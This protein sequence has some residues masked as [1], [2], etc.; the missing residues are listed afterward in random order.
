MAQATLGIIGGSGLYAVERLE[1]AR[2]VRVETPFGL[3]SDD[4]AIGRI[5]GIDVA[6][7]PRHGKGHRLSPTEVPVRA[8]IWALKSL[9]VERIVS[10]SAVGSLRQELEP[11]H[12]VVPD[13]LIDRTR[14]RTHTFFEGGLVVHIAFA[15]PF[16][17]VL[18]PL[19][20][21]AA[22][23]AGGTVHEGG[24]LVTM[25][26]PQFSTKAESRMYRQWGADLIGMTAIPEAK[27]A[28]EAEICYTTLACVTDYD[29]W[30]P[31]HDSVTVDLIVA[32]LL[33]NVG[34]A[35]AIIEAVAADLAAAGE[36]RCGCATALESAIITS[37]DAIPEETRRRYEPLI[38][39]YL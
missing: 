14:D 31:E 15:D 12:L 5:A 13:Q 30:H 38:G 16:C 27:L 33:A 19:V 22:R 24:T 28:R 34:M 11:R 10:V 36:R 32:N 39:K 21:E 26:G 35:K 8:N 23:G 18:S 25:E 2:E 4:I 3:P 1:H 9:G 6:F 29:V 17:P 7:L 37:R 20:V